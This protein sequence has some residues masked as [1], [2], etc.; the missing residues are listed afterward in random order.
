M[1]TSMEARLSGADPSFTRELREQLV[2]AQGAVKRQLLRGELRNS[3][4][5]GNSRPMPSRRA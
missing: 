5:R 2:Q 1:M 4:R 3:I